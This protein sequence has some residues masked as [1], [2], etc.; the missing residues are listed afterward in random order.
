MKLLAHGTQRV[1]SGGSEVKVIAPIVP[2]EAIIVRCGF[3]G[4][5]RDSRI[6]RTHIIQHVQRVETKF[7]MV[8]RFEICE[9]K[10]ASILGGLRQ[11]SHERIN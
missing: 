4:K 2:V 10:R 11:V 1:V 3:V 9:S 7:L 6:T 5:S 8:I